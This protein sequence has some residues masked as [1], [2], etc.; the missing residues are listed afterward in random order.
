MFLQLQIRIVNAQKISSLQ[1]VTK[2]LN[3]VASS[4]PLGMWPD[5]EVTKIGKPTLLYISLSCSNGQM[6]G[7]QK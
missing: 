2:L 4:N 6:Y 1:L 7:G 5:G 3:S